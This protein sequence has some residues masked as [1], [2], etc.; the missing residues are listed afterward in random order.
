MSSNFIINLLAIACLIP[1]LPA[2][3]GFLDD[4]LKAVGKGIKEGAPPP[5]SLM[6]NADNQQH[7]ATL[8]VGMRGQAPGEIGQSNNKTSIFWV[9][10]KGIWH[11]PSA[12]QKAVLIV[13]NQDRPRE[14]AIDTVNKKLYW[15]SGA[16][17]STNLYNA[18]LD[19]SNVTLVTKSLGKTI[20]NLS[21]DT[22]RGFIYWY[23]Q[24]GVMED[25]GTLRGSIIALDLNRYNRRDV[26]NGVPDLL[27][28][29]VDIGS[30]LLCWVSIDR[31]LRGRVVDC[32]V[33]T[34]GDRREIIRST[35]FDE[36]VIESV[37]FSSERGGIYFGTFNT[38]CPEGCDFTY[39]LFKYEHL[40][41]PRWKRVVCCLDGPVVYYDDIN[42]IVYW[43]RLQGWGR[44]T[45]LWQARIGSASDKIINK[46]MVLKQG[47]YG[48]RDVSVVLSQPA[49]IGLL[50]P[51]FAISERW[52]VCRGYNVTGSH[53]D[54]ASLDLSI[55]SSSPSKNGCTPTTAKSSTGKEVLSP[56]SGIV[57][58][59][60]NGDT[61]DMLCLWLDEKKDV[62]SDGVPDELFLKIG[63]LE[64][65]PPVKSHVEAG[66]RLGTITAPSPDNGGYSHIHIELV[67]GD[68]STG[69]SKSAIRV[70]FAGEVAFQGAPNMT[71]DGSKNQWQGTS[72]SR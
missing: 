2:H 64:G 13:H 54:R 67:T 11:K 33:P 72:L 26:E 1:T 51:P 32:A 49:R 4:V 27:S 61:R 25:D 10:T 45:I 9:D 56:A 12:N 21:V 31:N 66:S 14:L 53:Q 28:L 15:V 18:N 62:N 38:E 60:F 20:S 50:I 52:Y 3:A 59:H 22:S 30:G 36:G 63:H 16:A 68:L 69:C 29:K 43:I 57:L 46:V 47:V 35:D 6:P 8:S 19:G 71:Y 23:E 42:G 34:G 39:S 41:S 44:P 17:G 70:P 7:P 24:G 5:Q 55:D 40:N 37:L 48:E 58:S 65:M